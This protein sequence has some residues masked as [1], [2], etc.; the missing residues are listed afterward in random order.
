MPPSH[1]LCFDHTLHM[2]E[3]LKKENSHQ[4]VLRGSKT[5]IICRPLP[6]VY[7]LAKC[8]LVAT[9]GWR[10]RQSV[11]TRDTIVRHLGCSATWKKMAARK[12]KPHSP[13]P[14]LPLLMTVEASLIDFFM[15]CKKA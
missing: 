11:W 7:S 14:P 3:D 13:P 15:V 5:A 10:E 8:F 2:T 1:D 4:L 9:H 6:V 12:Q